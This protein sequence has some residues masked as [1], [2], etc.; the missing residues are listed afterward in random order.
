MILCYNELKEVLK[1]YAFINDY[2]LRCYKESL[3][4]YK[5]YDENTIEMFGISQ[6]SNYDTDNVT[7]FH[8]NAYNFDSAKS[9]E[10]MVF[11]NNYSIFYR[12]DE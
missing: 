8:Y 1:W 4:L 3:T 7:T 2:N 5:E 12:K 10:I 11:L 6:Y 9:N